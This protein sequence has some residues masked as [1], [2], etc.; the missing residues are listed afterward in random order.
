MRQAY[1]CLEHEGRKVKEGVV[2]DE[3]C[4]EWLH[5]YGGETRSMWLRNSLFGK[6]GR[7]PLKFSVL[8]DD[9]NPYVLAFKRYLLKARWFLTLRRKEQE[10]LRTTIGI[11]SELE[12]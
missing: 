11:P 3:Q 8:N 1:E 7:N 6:A 5:H 12:E 4:V 10:R 2:T 9:R